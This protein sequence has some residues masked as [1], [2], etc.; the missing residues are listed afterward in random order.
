MS[1]TSRSSAGDSLPP[2]PSRPSS[3]RPS[4]GLNVVSDKS[5]SP[6]VVSQLPSFLHRGPKPWVCSA[7]AYSIRIFNEVTASMLVIGRGKNI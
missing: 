6:D 1:S 3:K 7:A 4:T 2:P 5:G